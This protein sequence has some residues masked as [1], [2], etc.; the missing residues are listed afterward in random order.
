MRII[1]ISNEFFLRIII[2]CLYIGCFMTIWLLHSVFLIYCVFLG[3]TLRVI[4]ELYTF[5]IQAVILCGILLIGNWHITHLLIHQPNIAL[6]LFILSCAT[7]IGGYCFGKIFGGPKVFLASPNKTISGVLGSFFTVYVCTSYMHTLSYC[8]Q[9]SYIQ[10]GMYCVYNITGD[11]IASQLKRNV[12]VK[13]YGNF[14]GP[15]GGLIDRMDS[16]LFT[17]FCDIIIDMI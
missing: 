9:Y 17:C 7:D 12:N 11:L 15:H 4:Y 6:S 5:N 3:I 13:H 14:L 2:G 8:Y 10:A 1:Y 16:L